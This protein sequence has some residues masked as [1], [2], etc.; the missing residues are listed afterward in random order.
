MA[1]DPAGGNGQPDRTTT[2][3]HSA[4]DVR[5]GEI[6]LRTPARRFIFIGGLV[7][8]VVLFILLTLWGG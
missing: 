7:G 6:V 8:L 1:E 5:Q 2:G 4:R 3:R